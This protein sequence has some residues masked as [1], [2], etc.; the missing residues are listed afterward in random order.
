MKTVRMLLLPASLMASGV[1]TGRFLPSIDSE[2]PRGKNPGPPPVAL[3]HSMGVVADTPLKR[4]GNQE[5]GKMWDLLQ[6]VDKATL[7]ELPNLWEELETRAKADTS[8]RDAPSPW[9]VM[10]AERWTELDPGAAADFFAGKPE[11]AWMLR[12]VFGAWS[13][14]DPSAA[15]NALSALTES[16]HRQLAAVGIFAAAAGNPAELISWGRKLTFLEGTKLSETAFDAVIPP[17]ALHG[18]YAFDSAACLELAGHLPPWFRQRLEALKIL[19]AASGDL[20]AALAAIDGMKLDND[21]AGRLCRNLLPLA[22]THPGRLLDILGHLAGTRGP[23]WFRWDDDNAIP[24]MTLLAKAAPDRVESLLNDAFSDSPG[25]EYHRFH[26]A[27][28]LMESDP[29]LALRLAPPGTFWNEELWGPAP[30]A[31]IVSSPARTLELVREAP[32]SP[33]RDSMMQ[34]AL[35]EMMGNTPEEAKAWLDSLPAG[36]LQNIARTTMEYTGSPRADL[37]QAAASIENLGTDRWNNARIQDVARIML[38]KDQ[39][40]T[41][42]EVLSWPRGEAR[43]AALEATAK[44]WAAWS[45]PEALTWAASVPEDSRSRVISGILQTWAAT[46]PAAASEYLSALPEGAARDAPAAGF[47]RGLAGIDPAGALQ[48]VATIQDSPL[49]ATT[50]AEIAENWLRTDPEAARRA[51]PLVPGLTVEEKG[52][53]AAFTTPGQ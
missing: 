24:A 41:V 53:L 5:T 17:E 39:A 13:R 20:P 44:A 23:G 26:L 1:V 15:L 30:V 8:P 12:T 51:I 7:E 29:R 45:T 6:R 43:D 52:K 19:D 3:A 22:G 14:T 21:G 25:R 31:R 16:R 9:M 10:L 46:E 34:A 33:L 38:E 4:P 27:A 37:L 47:A 42:A 35:K 49:R 11:R 28:G 32:P 36:E 48:W 50:L 2:D 40:G 18:A